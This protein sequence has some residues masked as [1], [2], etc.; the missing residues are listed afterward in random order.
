M[1]AKVWKSWHAEEVV[2]DVF[3]RRCSSVLSKF[4]SLSGVCLHLEWYCKSFLRRV[5]CGLYRSCSCLRPSSSLMPLIALANVCLRSVWKTL[6]Q[7]LPDNE[8]PDTYIHVNPVVPRT[9]V[10]SFVAI[11]LLPE[12][13][14]TRWPVSWFRWIHLDTYSFVVLPPCL[15]AGFRR[16]GEQPSGRC[17]LQHASQGTALCYLVCWGMFCCIFLIIFIISVTLF[18]LCFIFLYIKFIY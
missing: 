2:T 18:K 4:L 1:P 5:L 12:G 3:L 10:Q 9:T 17:R 7:W 13:D 6:S 11:L 14:L 15:S 16:L 8:W